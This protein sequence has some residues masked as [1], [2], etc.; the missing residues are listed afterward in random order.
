MRLDFADPAERR[1]ED[2]EVTNAEAVRKKRFTDDGIYS[3][4]LFG[5]MHGNPRVVACRC[6]AVEGDYVEG[7][8]CDEC[9]ERAAPKDSRLGQ[10][11]WV[12]A[13]GVRL[14][15]PVFVPMLKAYFGAA[16]WNKYLDAS[17]IGMDEDGRELTGA[18]DLRFGPNA[19]IPD[20]E[21]NPEL[22]AIGVDEMARNIGDVLDMVHDRRK[23][24]P[25]EPLY[26][27]MKANLDKLTADRIPVFSSRLRPAVFV[28]GRTLVFPQVNTVFTQLVKTAATLRSTGREGIPALRSSLALKLQT[29]WCQAWEHV[30]GGL[31][32]KEGHIRKA[33]LGSRLN[34]SA[35]CV[36]VPGRDDMDFDEIDIP[37]L[38]GV[39]L[40]RF[41]LIRT[42]VGLDGKGH[43]AAIRR[44]EESVRRFDPEAHA[45]MESI[46]RET[47]G[48]EVLFNRNP[49]ISLGS[50]MKMR[51]RRIKT[52]Y[53]D[54]TISLSNNILAQMGGDYDGDVLNLFLLLDRRHKEHFRRLE[55]S[56]MLLSANDGRLNPFFHLDKD[57]MV[58][59]HLLTC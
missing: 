28:G 29:L 27:L 20:S 12:D 8:L 21:P 24:D 56:R 16:R 15:N 32:G 58:G 49:T 19:G 38:A 11:A 50:I 40:L 31:S 26:R 37:Y 51:V 35:R 17:A 4:R 47:G 22:M 33:L 25:K 44:W 10:T 18:A 54:C 46:A 55:P 43:A 41:H 23:T 6:G 5:R 9:G 3:E 52:D 2:R 7:V 59:A 30:V 36:I 57:H 42:W 1:E 13:G 14:F 53:G 45:M 39:E 48:L 34:F